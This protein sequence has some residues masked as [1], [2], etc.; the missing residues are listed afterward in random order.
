MFLS[1]C[2][3]FTAD[4]HRTF[5]LPFYPLWVVY[6]MHHA[7]L[8]HD[9]KNTA[10]STA[11]RGIQNRNERWETKTQKLLVIHDACLSVSESGILKFPCLYIGS[12]KCEY[13]INKCKLTIT[14]CRTGMMSGVGSPILN[15]G[16]VII[17][18]A[19]DLSCQY[20]TYTN[21]WHYTVL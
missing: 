16:V 15:R 6:V 1:F 11:R 3:I 4:F 17:K 5:S 14:H 19:T 2:V 20:S 7:L 12:E 13:V 9:L 18:V 8:E 10:R 21:M